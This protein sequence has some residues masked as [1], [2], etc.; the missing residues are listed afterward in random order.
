MN[1]LAVFKSI[2]IV[3][4]LIVLLLFETAGVLPLNANLSP[5][6]INYVVLITNRRVISELSMPIKQNVGHSCGQMTKSTDSNDHFVVLLETLGWKEFQPGK[7][8]SINHHW[9]KRLR[10]LGERGKSVRSIYKGIKEKG[11]N[12][13][14]RLSLGQKERVRD[15]IIL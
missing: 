7:E 15:I 4:I 9:K 3:I 6:T 5:I 12:M 14:H 8:E 1:N 10:D 11:C 13:Y 2:I